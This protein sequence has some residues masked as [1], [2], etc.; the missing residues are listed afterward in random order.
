MEWRILK[1]YLD[2]I[3]VPTDNPPNIGAFLAV[4]LLAQAALACCEL[5]GSKPFSRLK[6]RLLLIIR[7]LE[8]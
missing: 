1:L 4:R 2:F 5:K 6:I 3:Q 7:Q 8:S